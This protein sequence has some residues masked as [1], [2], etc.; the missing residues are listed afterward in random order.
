MTA[1]IHPTAQV[2]ASAA[3]G[4]GAQIWLHCQV[5]DHAVI[6]AESILGK[7]VYVDTGVTVGARSKIQNNV[8]LFAGVVIEDGVFL[9]PH[10]CFTNDRV[11]R[12]INPDGTLK[13][14]A[15]WVVTA[16]R[17]G[18]G[19]SV[20]A[21]TTVVC[22]ITIGAW[23]MIGAGSVVT[24]SIPAFALAYGT[25]ARVVGW[26]T[27]SG[28]RAHFDDDGRFE[29]RDGTVLRRHHTADG[30]RVELVA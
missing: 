13:A 14:A 29:G 10:V 25:P 9:G 23:A 3:V 24:R 11:P 20:G 27:P 30:D 17:V 19:A 2:A 12:A 22:G 15:D 8:S 28:E 4:D 21:N 18:T 5:R 1:R 16:T 7:N 6:G 26:V